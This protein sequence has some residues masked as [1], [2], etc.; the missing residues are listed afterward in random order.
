M[1]MW[2]H[3][4]LTYLITQEIAAAIGC[5]SKDPGGIFIY[6]LIQV[7]RRPSGDGVG[8]T[9]LRWRIR[10][11]AADCVQ[12]KPVLYEIGLVSPQ[13]SKQ[14]GF[15]KSSLALGRLVCAGSDAFPSG[16]DT[17][18]TRRVPVTLDLALLT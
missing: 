12:I 14:F 18:G 4:T 17:I 13:A 11:A 8:R 7:P 3:P 6:S 9:F 5:Q 15:G 10:G 1:S 16:L 2:M